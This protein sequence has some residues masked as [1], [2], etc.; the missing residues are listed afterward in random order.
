MGPHLSAPPQ[1]CGQTAG[2]NYCPR[3]FADKN[4]P[5]VCISSDAQRRPRDTDCLIA[6]DI[7]LVAG[8][9]HP[10]EMAPFTTNHRQYGAAGDLNGVHSPGFIRLRVVGQHAVKQRFFQYRRA[11]GRRVDAD[12]L[13]SN[14]VR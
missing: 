1:Y 2:G 14:R 8:P 12:Q 11:D 6:Q 7:P 3:A 13:L 9:F 5:Y 10:E 4:S